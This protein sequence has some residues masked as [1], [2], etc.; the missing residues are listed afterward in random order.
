MTGG[1]ADRRWGWKEP[2]TH[3]MIDRLMACIPGLKYI[4]VVR[5]GLDMAFSAN[6]TQLRLWGPHFL[7]ANLI[8]VNPRNSLR[9]WRAV[10]ERILRIGRLLDG[11]FLLLNFDELCHRPKPAL[12]AFFDF[13]GVEPSSSARD[14]LCGCI[15]PPRSIGRFKRQSLSA[16]DRIDIDFVASLG[17]DTSPG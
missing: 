10:H 9:Y 4:H 15:R 7:A 17:F 13:L 2:N 6:Q 5:N 8:E 16:L 1:P 3:V 12:E 14:Q 11:R